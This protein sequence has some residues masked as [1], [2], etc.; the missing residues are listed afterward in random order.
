M[1]LFFFNGLEISNV[2][3]FFASIIIVTEVFSKC[4]R[5]IRANMKTVSWDE[6]V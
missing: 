1:F 2:Y 5:Q 3:Y 4:E 6:G